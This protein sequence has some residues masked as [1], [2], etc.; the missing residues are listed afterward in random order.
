MLTSYAQNF[1]DV[2]LWRALKDVEKG[3]YIDVGAQAP[4]FDSVSL[5]FYEKGWRGVHIEPYSMFAQTLREARPDETVIEAFIGGE[6]GLSQFYEVQ[7]TG[8]STGDRDLAARHAADGLTVVSKTVVSMPLAKILETYRDRD[9]HWLKI[10]V[11]GHEADVIDSWLPSAVRPWIVVVEATVPRSQTPSFEHWEPALLG[12]G[13]DF[14]YFDGLN[15]FYVSHS[16]PQ[17]AEVFGPGPNYFDKFQLTNLSEFTQTLTRNYES[18]LTDLRTRTQQLEARAVE[19]EGKLASDGE[20]LIRL[21]DNILE[22]DRHAQVLNERIDSIH[23]STS[24]R[25]TAPFRWF[26]AIARK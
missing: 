25:I 5:A 21:R 6:P 4:I 16:H 13:Y 15:R 1:E 7:G 8:L 20:E 26:G 24:W 19:L 9:I 14:V 12:L 22:R 17:R 3:F 11:E 18:Q 23:R 10:D 2:L